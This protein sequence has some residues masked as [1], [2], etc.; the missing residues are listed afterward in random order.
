MDVCDASAGGRVVVEPVVRG[1]C[2]LLL[3]GDPLVAVGEDTCGCLTQDDE[4]S[5]LVNFFSLWLNMFLWF[6]SYNSAVVSATLG[7]CGLLKIF[8][9]PN[10]IPGHLLVALAYSLNVA[11]LVKK[12]TTSCRRDAM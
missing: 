11:T 1:D 9:F 3:P 4:N 5:T 12:G 8:Q 7:F 6:F 2:P 10:E